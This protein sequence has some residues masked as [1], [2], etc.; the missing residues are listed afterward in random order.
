MATAFGYVGG[1]VM[2]Y[3]VYANWVSMHRWGMTAHRNIEAIRQRAA[4]RNI[5]DYLPEQP[6]QVSQ[7][8]KI[9]APTPVGYRHGARLCYLS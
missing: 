6:E 7:L 2:G 9:L 5:V 3:V 1:S 8:R 4:N